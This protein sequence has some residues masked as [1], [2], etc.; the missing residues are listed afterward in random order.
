MAS[1]TNVQYQ[2]SLVGSGSVG[3]PVIGIGGPMDFGAFTTTGTYTVVGSNTVTGCSANMA[4]SATVGVTALVA[5][6]ITL[7]TGVGDTLCSPATW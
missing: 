1:S 4:G 5:P 7:S 3:G 6:S 2:L